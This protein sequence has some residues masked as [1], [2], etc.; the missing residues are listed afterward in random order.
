MSSQES[1]PGENAAE[2]DELSRS[3]SSFSS[4]SSSSSSSSFSGSE[5]GSKE[6]IDKPHMTKMSRGGS[7]GFSN[8]PQF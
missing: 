1:S 4:S 3:R 8:R 5:G 6:D 2:D 7:A